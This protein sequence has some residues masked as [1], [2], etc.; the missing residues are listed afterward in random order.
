MS[1]EQ[2]VVYCAGLT[3]EG[4]P[5]KNRGNRMAS[6]P[7]NCIFNNKYCHHHEKQNPANFYQ[8]AFLVIWNVYTCVKD[9][10]DW[11]ENKGTEDQES[12]SAESAD[13]I[14]F[15]VKIVALVCLL[16]LP[17]IFKHCKNEDS[18]NTCEGIT[19][20]GSQCTRGGYFFGYCWQHVNQWGGWHF[21]FLSIWIANIVSACL[22]LYA[23]SNAKNKKILDL[24]TGL[25]GNLFSFIELYGAIKTYCCESDNENQKG[26]FAKS[27]VTNLGV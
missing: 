27:K 4:N 8:T 7:W 1:E 21:L 16:I 9:V 25:A 18:S 23:Y 5:C 3:K 26:N 10:V 20:K 14:Q 24:L 13:W 22:N 6:S 15:A 11:M 12:E 17:H 2:E 19:N